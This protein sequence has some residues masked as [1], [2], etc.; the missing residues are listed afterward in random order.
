MTSDNK[1]YV[2]KSHD[3]QVKSTSETSVLYGLSAAAAILTLSVVTCSP[4]YSGSNALQGNDISLQGNGFMT[5]NHNKAFNMKLDLAKYVD[6]GYYKVL[7]KNNSGRADRSNLAFYVTDSNM[8]SQIHPNQSDIS[9]ER[10]KR[11]WGS[12]TPMFMVADRSAPTLYEGKTSLNKIAERRISGAVAIV[13]ESNSS[14]PIFEY[15]A[16]PTQKT[17]GAI[18]HG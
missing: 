13:A 7:L 8:D 17:I 6:N 2:N 1:T 10:F 12:S 9:H 15:S 18:H 5:I 3:N 4:I 11:R 14:R 16:I